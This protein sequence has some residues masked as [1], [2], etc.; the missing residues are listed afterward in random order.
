MILESMRV[1]GC[2]TS[3]QLAVSIGYSSVNNTFRRCVAELMEKGRISYLSGQHQGQAPEDLSSKTLNS[4]GHRVLLFSFLSFR[5][6]YTVSQVITS[7]R[8]CRGSEDI[9]TYMYITT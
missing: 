9:S 8:S 4:R 6:S 1:N 5:V 7:I 2:Q 3:R